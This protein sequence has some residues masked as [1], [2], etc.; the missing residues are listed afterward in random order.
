MITPASTNL[1]KGSTQAFTCTAYYSDSTT[2]NV[3]ASVRWSSGDP[4]IASITSG[5]VATGL[6]E[7]SVTIIVSS[8]GL[9]AVASTAL[10][11]TT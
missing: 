9:G 1:H 11:V 4:T 5:G 3:T 10:I 8:A 6:K 2:A 7:G